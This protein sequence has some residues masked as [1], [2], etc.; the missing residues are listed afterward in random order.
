MANS[1][2]DHLARRLGDAVSRR[3]GLAR[4]L[5]VLLGLFGVG[6]AEAQRDTA[7]I[8]RTTGMHCSEDLQ[9]CSGRCV[10]KQHRGGRCA[11]RRRTRKSHHGRNRRS[12]ATPSPEATATASP[13]STV[14]ATP[15]SS[16]VDTATPTNTATPADTATPTATAT[17]TCTVCASGCPFTTIEAAVAAAD[18]GDTITI[19][20]GSYTPVTDSPSDMA[21]IPIRK[22]LTIKACDP[23]NVPVLNAVGTNQGEYLFVLGPSDSSGWSCASDDAV[24]I[25]IDGMTMQGSVT[26][27]V[28][29]MFTSC[30]TRWT[31][32]NVLI[33][34]FGLTRD[35]NSV[36]EIY[37][38][39]ETNVGLI[40]DSVIRNTRTA[41][42]SGRSSGINLYGDTGTTV[43]LELKNTTVSGNE[44]YGGAVT[45]EGGSVVLSGNTSIT[46]NKALG[47]YG[48]GVVIWRILPASLVIR[49]TA[50]ITN[51][52]AATIGGGLLAY[53]THTIIGATPTSISGNQSPT[54]RNYYKNPTCIIN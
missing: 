46:A 6:V 13:D 29:A 49:D 45:I 28:G 34:D 44:G 25:V 7:E 32:R 33:Q 9:C 14:T 20:P 22:D 21:T 35:N 11:R 1:G 41:A 50:T 26:S 43:V 18:P 37:S 27:G 8:C 47:G 3:T 17:P 30:N 15:T 38:F 16:P 42:N 52:Y 39:N 2:F 10:G 12:S 53:S 31:L 4:L 5:V 40:K 51:N 23:D 48:G 19:G 54:C 24:T 36:I